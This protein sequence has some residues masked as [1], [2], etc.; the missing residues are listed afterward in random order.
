MLIDF[1][2]K[3][4]FPIH[5]F[6]NELDKWELLFLNFLISHKSEEEVDLIC[7]HPE[8]LKDFN[9]M[10]Q[11]YI[12]AKLRKLSKEEVM[13][14]FTRQFEETQLTPLIYVNAYR[15]SFDPDA[16]VF[17]TKILAIQR[18]V[19]MLFH[20]NITTLMDSYHAGDLEDEVS[21]DEFLEKYCMK[22]K[23]ILNTLGLIALTA[24]MDKLLFDVKGKGGL[25]KI[26]QELRFS[27]FVKLFQKFNE[28]KELDTQHYK[29]LSKQQAITIEKLESQ[30]KRKEDVYTKQKE[31]QRKLTNEVKELN[32][33]VADLENKTE[34][35][36]DKEMVNRLYADIQKKDQQ[37]EKLTSDLTHLKEK[38][39]TMYTT[40]IENLNLQVATLKS[41]LRDKTGEIRDCK[42]RI[43]ELQDRTVENMLQEFLDTNGFTESLSNILTPFVKPKEAISENNELHTDSIK[44]TPKIGYCMIE[45]NT[46]YIVFPNQS[47]IEI[48]DLS[49]STYI[50]EWQFVKVDE[51]GHFRWAYV[52]KFEEHERDYSIHEFA[53]VSIQ[54]AD[55]FIEKAN[56]SLVKLENIPSSIQLRDKQ[57]VAVDA[58]NQFI[59]FYRPLHFNADHYLKSIKSRGQSVYYVLKVFPNGVLVRDIETG[60]ELFKM[61]KD[62]QE[63]L[64][65]QQIL[66]LHEDEV[67]S[68]Y[69]IPKFYTLSSYYQNGEFGVVQI[70]N[71]TP[72]LQKLSGEVVILKDLPYAVES[73]QIIKI[74][75]FNNYLF[76]KKDEAT[77]ESKRKTVGSNSSSVVKKSNAYEKIDVTKEVLIIGN[78]TYENSYKMAFLKKGC[79]ANVIDGYL[80]WGKIKSALK[81]K[82]AVLVVTEFVSHDNMWRIK[83]E[84]LDVP[85]I[86]SEFEGANRLLEQFEST[87]SEDTQVI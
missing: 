53:M 70:K 9:K 35:I 68:V 55:V 66:C 85:V 10:S 63:E 38:P 22:D 73:G 51:E 80:S 40:M 62:S 56:G 64:K 29:I 81:E 39:M 69:N 82:D 50:G 46:H 33:K 32:K 18:F 1:L 31:S 65:E 77:P 43:Q 78:I 54:G 86:Y 58:K 7:D 44:P 41:E 5:Q 61:V 14:K 34:D 27:I 11:K 6:C 2:S 47:R 52:S 79:R 74:D 84:P 17:S 4:D 67:I 25:S 12:G 76:T 24:K 60:E 20:K 15:F 59:R 36:A 13:D 72:Y 71:E 23:P 28:I 37:I 21:P 42:K 75:E 48:K 45:N 19:E 16:V 57:I 87:V 26:G 3:Q 83:E 49:A 30:M 8:I